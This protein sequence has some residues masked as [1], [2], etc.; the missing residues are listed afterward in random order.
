MKQISKQ[1]LGNKCAKKL[2]IPVERSHPDYMKYYR[3]ARKEIVKNAA[4]KWSENN[5]ELKQE[6]WRNWYN[7]NKVKQKIKYQ[8]E[9]AEKL[10]RM[11]SWADRKAIANFYEN[12][13][14]DHHVDHIIP[15]R[16]KTVSG[17]HIIENLQYLH[18]KENLKKG[19][20]F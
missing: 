16:G 17:L 3:I 7:R 19:N 20:K 9:K 15:L 6:Q 18:A 5:A 12:C 4:D 1:R 8:F 13:P 10:K 2:D 11:P 14:E